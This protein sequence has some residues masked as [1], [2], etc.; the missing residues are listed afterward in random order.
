MRGLAALL[1]THFDTVAQAA[2]R[3]QGVRD[4]IRIVKGDVAHWYRS[5]LHLDWLLPPLDEGLG[6]PTEDAFDH[7]AQMRKG[8]ELYEMA[9]R[10]AG[11]LLPGGKYAFKRLPLR[12]YT[13]VRYDEQGTFCD[14]LEER[15]VSYGEASSG[16]VRVQDRKH[17]RWGT[18]TLCESG[19]TQADIRTL[20]PETS[21]LG[22][23]MFP[24]A[25]L[26]QLPRPVPRLRHA[27]APTFEEILGIFESMDRVRTGTIDQATLEAQLTARPENAESLML[28]AYDSHDLSSR[29]RALFSPAR[30]ARCVAGGTVCADDLVTYSLTNLDQH[31]RLVFKVRITALAGELRLGFVDEG[32]IVAGNINQDWQTPGFPSWHMESSGEVWCLGKKV[33]DG[34]R[35]LHDGDVV[36]ALLDQDTGLLRFLV[37]G[38]SDPI[39][40]LPSVLGLLTPGIQGTARDCQVELLPF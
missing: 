17:L 20:P 8:G 40:T 14:R 24:T 38:A 11:S 26:Y 23:K 28:S 18:R 7:E 37:E 19:A 22:V 29:V 34:G 2:S 30:C 16:V 3:G 27:V 13:Y 10:S 36:C 1:R 39:G 9:R 25:T 33:S 4:L 5:P 31:S 15:F 6:P 21:P 32:R 35:R 12:E